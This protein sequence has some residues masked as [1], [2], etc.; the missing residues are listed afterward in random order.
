MLPLD[1]LRRLAR[2]VPPPSVADAGVAELATWALVRGCA[3]IVNPEPGAP[4][5]FLDNL[6]RAGGVGAFPA[7][8][9]VD[10]RLDPVESALL[11]LLADGYSVAQAAAQ[12]YLSSRTAQRRLNAARVAL[13]VRTTREAVVAWTA[14]TRRPSPDS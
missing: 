7:S 6:R 3:L 8:S 4:R 2:P 10:E 12:L 1:V 13:G 14:L 11:G 9:R 5:E